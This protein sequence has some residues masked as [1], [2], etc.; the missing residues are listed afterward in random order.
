MEPGGLTRRAAAG[1]L[2]RDMS[3]PEPRYDRGESRRRRDPSAP[4]PPTRAERAR[5][6]AA[7]L[8]RPGE[9]LLWAGRPV[10][11][12]WFE[13]WWVAMGV[14]AFFV[15][16]PLRAWFVAGGRGLP[17]P[18]LVFPAVGL[19]GLLSP[20][21]HRILSSFAVYAVTDLR[22]IRMLPPF[23]DSVRGAD[24]EPPYPYRAPDARGRESWFFFKTV[25]RSRS[26]AEHIHHDG[27]RHL[28]P[29][30][31]NAA[32][33]AL[34]RLVA[35]TEGLR[36]LERRTGARPAPPSPRPANLRT[37]RIRVRR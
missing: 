36:S 24:I 8:L 20:L 2:G 12:W 10:P 34:L 5:A 35:A 28:A 19:M 29:E 37:R 23:S 26:G 32:G 18:M 33:E 15:A 4:P 1:R 11:T 13:G 25:T 31:A 16:L 21:L 6:R 14:G 22:A 30:D 17:A 27:F 9:S 7:R 3:A